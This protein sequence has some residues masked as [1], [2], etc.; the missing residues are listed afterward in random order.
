MTKLI[1]TA[2]VAVAV[3]VTWVWFRRQ[4]GLEKPLTYGRRSDEQ[5]PSE[6]APV[7][8]RTDVD[9][10]PPVTTDGRQEQSTET[11]HEPTTER[12]E[13]CASAP[14]HMTV[15][16][17]SEIAEPVST[18]TD[19]VEVGPS[20]LDLNPPGEPASAAPV[21]P[22]GPLPTPAGVSCPSSNQ[23]IPHRHDETVRESEE[24]QASSASP[25]IGSLQRGETVAAAEVPESELSVPQTTP[26]PCADAVRVDETAL[27]PGPAGEKPVE[28]PAPAATPAPSLPATA[29]TSG[30]EAHMEV[31]ENPEPP[32]A[33]REPLPKA[34]SFTE[35]KPSPITKTSSRNQRKPDATPR[36]DASLPIRLQ[37]VFGRGRTVKTLALVAHRREEMPGSIEVIVAYGR[38]RLSEWSADSYEPVPVSEVPYALSEGVVWQ[39]R[40]GAQR[41]RWEL[42]KRELYV[43]AAGEL[44]GFVTRRK[45]QR[46]WLNIPHVVLAKDSLRDQVLAALSEAGCTTPE[47]NDSTT[48][49]VPSGWIL[50]RDVKPTRAVP[51]RDERDI[52]NVLCPAHEIEAQFVGGIKLERNVWL[53]GFPPRIRFTGEMGSGFQVLIDEQL[54]Q[55]ASDGAFE[56][57]GWDA[58][59]EHRLWFGDQAET[60]S[61]RTMEEEW[62]CWPAHDFVTGLMAHAGDRFASRQQIRCWLAHD[63]VKFSA[64]S[65]GMTSVPKQFLRWS[66]LLQFGRSPLTRFTPTSVQPA[67]CH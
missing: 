9:L 8:A 20:P 2:L 49:G 54:A 36:A 11:S 63:R 21:E 6:D 13:S 51:M 67:L 26:A 65:P 42:C 12:T 18:P 47:V 7:S 41:W 66:P 5:P 4:P 29:P 60:Y 38:L 33:E 55:L 45:D 50:F 48:P 3:A 17:A 35:P 43:L 37:L 14:T 39:A 61:L 58:E 24:T 53:S 52:L 22:V 56:S 25:P 1:I 15:P 32:L 59:G 27:E 31:G 28:I 44:R 30:D 19:A 34:R 40:S 16:T 64:A 23:A 57:P 46:L 62:E 10:R